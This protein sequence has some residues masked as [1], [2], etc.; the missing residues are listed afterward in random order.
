MYFDRQSVYE[1]G[2]VCKSVLKIDVGRWT[3]DV[4]RWTLE[5][6]VETRYLASKN[7]KDA[8]YRVSTPNKKDAKTASFF[9]LF[10]QTFQHL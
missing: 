3:L 8:K 5:Y 1:A 4:G 2:V 7:K 6:F 10:N 9:M